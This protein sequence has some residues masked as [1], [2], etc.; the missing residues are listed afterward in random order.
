MINKVGLLYLPSQGH[1]R[2]K[3]EKD[4]NTLSNKGY[5]RKVVKSKK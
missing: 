3:T 2:R 4:Y 5:C 1:A